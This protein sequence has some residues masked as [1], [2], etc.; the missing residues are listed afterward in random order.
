MAS[1]RFY[2]STRPSKKLMAVFSNPHEVIHFGQRGASDY[3]IHHDKTRRAFY[4]ARHRKN[5]NWLNPRSAGALS[6]W[7]LWGDSDNIEDNIRA[8]KKRFRLA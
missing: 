5:E 8:F 1:V 3:T 4:I 2:E 6:R 7:I